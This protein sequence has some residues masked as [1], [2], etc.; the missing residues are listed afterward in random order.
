MSFPF[1]LPA[2]LLLGWITVCIDP[3]HG[4]T[5]TGAVGEYA[6]EKD[7]VL[8]IGFLL[9]NWLCQVPGISHAALTRDGDYDVSLQARTDYANSNGFDGFVS[10]HLNAF[11]GAVQG[12]ETFCGS[13]D[14]GDPSFQTAVLVQEALLEAYGYT[15]RGVKDGGHLHVIR[16]TVMP[17]V[18]GEGS[19]LDY[20]LNWNESYLYAFDIDD[21]TGIQAWSYADAISSFYGLSSPSW[22]SGIILMDDL[23]A[24]FSLNDSLYWEERTSGAPWMGRCLVSAGGGAGEAQWSSMVPVNGSFIL[25]VWWTSGNE[26]SSSVCF[27]VTHSEG[28]TDVFLDQCEGG[29]EWVSSSTFTF[30]GQCSIRLLCHESAPGTVVADAVRLVPALGVEGSAFPEIQVLGNPSSSFTFLF[31]ENGHGSVTVFDLQGRVVG[32]ASGTGSATWV[33]VNLPSGVYMAREASTGGLV[34]LV[35]AR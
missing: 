8:E 23:S 7:V 3:G 18:L 13:L 34:K 24:G 12:T 28:V 29:G 10:I 5:S 35:L 14:P 26:N 25:E 32:E 31:P 21:H 11:N 17:A 20:T 30:D 1:S 15:D 6:L 9:Q 16:E 22:G 2:L 27:S 19:F 33:P 4:G